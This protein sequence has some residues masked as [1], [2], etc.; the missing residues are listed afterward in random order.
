MYALSLHDR[1]LLAALSRYARTSGFQPTGYT[2]GV[3]RR[4]DT[5]VVWD[6]AEKCVEVLTY[7]HD[8]V[9][10]RATVP[11][12]CVQQAVDALVALR[13]L[14]MGMASA[15]EAGKRYAAGEF[16]DCGNAMWPVRVEPAL[17][18]EPDSL[19]V[20]TRCVDCCDDDDDPMAWCDCRR[21]EECV[22]PCRQRA[23]IPTVHI[24]V[25]VVVPA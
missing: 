18:S 9:S 14:P 8:Y 12:D 13:M 5:Y 19:I 16:S 7:D 24:A 2:Q 15:F 17:E 25:P 10:R 22:G 6:R 4:G 20:P 3:W 23:H 21:N 1:A 11:V